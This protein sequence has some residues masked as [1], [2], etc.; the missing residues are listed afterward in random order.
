M[1]VSTV[2]CDVITAHRAPGVKKTVASNQ[3]NWLTYNLEMEAVYSYS[4]AT[5]QVP[6][7]TV[8]QPRRP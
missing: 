4:T 6:R 3:P 2:H 5:T 8:S 7:Y 1:Q